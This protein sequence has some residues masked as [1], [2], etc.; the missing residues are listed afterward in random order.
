MQDCP[1][2]T[3]QMT[4]TLIAT[5]PG[6]TSQ[7]VQYATVNSAAPTNTPVPPPTNTHRFRRPDQHT[8]AAADQYAGATADRDPL[9]SD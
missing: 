3:G 5:G 6:G 2:G 1:P 8:G 9:P 4:Y 7:A